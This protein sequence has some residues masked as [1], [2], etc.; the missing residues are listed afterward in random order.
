MFDAAIVS[1]EIPKDSNG[2]ITRYLLI[3][4]FEVRYWDDAFPNDK[5]EISLN[6]SRHNIKIDG[7]ISSTHYSVEVIA[8]TVKGD[9]PRKEVKFESGVPPGEFYYRILL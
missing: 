2:I 8:S 4:F 1:W 9:G 5:F 6:N 3:L 7:L